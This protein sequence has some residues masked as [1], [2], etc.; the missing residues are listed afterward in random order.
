MSSITNANSHRPPLLQ[1][2]DVRK[3][4][5]LTSLRLLGADEYD[6]LLPETH[7]LP[8][9][10]RPGEVIFGALY[11]RYHKGRERIIG[12]GMLVITDQRIILIDKKP[13]YLQEDDIAF[14]VVS[15]VD[16][17]F[18]GPAAT[19]TLHTR[20]GDIDVRTFNKRCG[21]QFVEAVQDMLYDPEREHRYYDYPN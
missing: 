5:V 9:L 20:M 1:D 14:D 3:A 4:E 11:G 17:S 12:R 8:R 10:L 6:L 7:C 16:I 15:G 19:V 13:L 21:R 2:S 18:A